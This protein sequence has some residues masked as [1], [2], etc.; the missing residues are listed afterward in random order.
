MK[1]PTEE[2]IK[3]KDEY[4]RRLDMM[5]AHG[6]TYRPFERWNQLSPSEEKGEQE[7][8]R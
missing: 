5:D 3:A 7:F 2:E 4:F 1:K 8:K 6:E